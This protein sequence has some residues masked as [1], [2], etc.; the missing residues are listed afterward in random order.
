MHDCSWT[1]SVHESHIDNRGIM[2]TW[3]LPKNLKK[4]HI[5]QKKTYLKKRLYLA[6]KIVAKAKKQPSAT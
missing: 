5:I 6:E 1:S 3:I 4:K 2:I